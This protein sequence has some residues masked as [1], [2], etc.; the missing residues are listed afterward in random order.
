LQLTPDGRFF[1]AV[2]SGDK[3]LAKSDV[4]KLEVVSNISLPA[5]IMFFG[6]REGNAFPSTE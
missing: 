6:I 1:H 4:S 3:A 2:A 5:K